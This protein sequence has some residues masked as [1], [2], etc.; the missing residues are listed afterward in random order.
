MADRRLQVFHA[1]ATTRNFTRAAESLFMSQPAVTVQIRQL[2]EQYQVKLFER[3]SSGVTLTAAGEL[4]FRY[5]EKIRAINDELEAR[6]GEMTGEM[7]GIFALG[8]STSIAESVLPRLLAEFNALYPQVRPRLIVGNTE[9]IV[10]QVLA[11]TLEVAVVGGPVAHEGLESQMCSEDALYAYCAPDYPLAS[12][13]S[14]TPRQ[15]RDY[16]YL[17]R[18]PGSG[19][20]ALA[21]AWFA[22]GGVK[23]DDLKILME[24]GSPQALKQVVHGGMGFTIASERLFA[25]DDAAGRIVRIPLKPAL[26]RPLLLISPKERFRTRLATTFGNFARQQLKEFLF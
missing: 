12:A 20:R 9:A 23:P 4:M 26:S 1:V 22:A 18:E 25:E 19:S 2:E 21:E 16:E 24:M 5:A 15:L 11:H 8:A 17:T 7:R 3:S 6:L 13:K 10:G 14:A